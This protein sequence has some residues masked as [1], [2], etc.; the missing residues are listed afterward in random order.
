[1]TPSLFF[2]PAVCG[3]PDPSGQSGLPAGV[4][5]T[6]Q[7]SRPSCSLPAHPPAGAVRL[8][9]LGDIMARPGR[10]AAALA[11]RH[12]REQH[13]ANIVLVN[14]ENS[15]GGVGITPATVKE[16]FAAGADV[17]TTGNHVWRHKECYPLLATAPA[18][19]RPANFGENTP[20]RGLT[21]LTLPAARIAVL[22][23][24]GRVFMDTADCPFRAADE[25]LAT[26][27]P[28]IS[29][30]F[31]DFHAEATSEKRA[32]VQY[33]DGR[34]SAVFGTHTHVQTF[35]ARISAK[36]TASLTDLGM[37]GVEEDSVL[38][39]AKEPVL[40][41]FLSGM[42]HAFRP[43]KG[44]GTVNGLLADFDASTGRA[45]ALCLVR[46]SPS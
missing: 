28:D 31:V 13:G 23:L 39:M 1:M 7:P 32:M 46:G 19:L 33:L 5:A 17:I 12:I 15:A 22:N 27:T 45:V 35:D 26:L 30:I 14:G 4:D 37:C 20:G 9:A 34:V 16:L 40:A 42:P 41:R 44:P 43:A 24:A 3:V 2:S 36:G 29:L 38:G 21:V 18:V 11:I 25:A 6:G 8:L 10:V